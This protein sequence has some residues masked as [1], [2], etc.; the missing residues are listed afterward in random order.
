[1]MDEPDKME[2]VSSPNSFFNLAIEGFRVG[3]PIC[4]DWIFLKWGI[5]RWPDHQMTWF[6]YA[7]FA[8]I[9]PE[10]SQ[11][12]AWIYRMVVSAKV[13]GS[14]ARTVK[15]Q[16]PIIARQR[17]TNL[18]PGLNARLKVL[19][20]SLASAKH[21]L[22]RVWDLG[23]RGN[24]VDMDEATKKA[25]DAIEQCDAS[26]RHIG[27]EFPNN[28]FVSRQYA[29]F[30]L[31]L[32]ANHQLA[33]E[34]SE[35][36]RLLQHGLKVTSDAA[37]DWGVHA[38]PN[39]PD[40]VVPCEQQQVAPDTQ[41]TFSETS[42][43]CDLETSRQDE[44]EGS[45]VIS[46]TIDQLTFPGVRN[47]LL[48][49]VIWFVL[50]FC[51]EIP[52]ILVVAE[53]LEE[54]M[55]A[56]LTFFEKLALLRTQG[57]AFAATGHL[58]AYRT[59]TLIVPLAP[60][61]E[62][63]PASVG[64]SWDL[65]DQLRFW[66]RNLSGSIQDIA[67]Y[68]SFENDDPAVTRAKSLIFDD[69]VLFWYHESHP[70]KS[71]S[72]AVDSA[73]INIV[74]HLMTLVNAKFPMPATFVNSSAV[75]NMVR[76]IPTICPL[77]TE[78]IDELVLFLQEYAADLTSLFGLIIY[79]SIG[80]AAFLALFAL[81]L[82]I[83]WIQNNKKKVYTC[84]TALPKNYVRQ[85]A[86]NLRVRRQDME[87]TTTQSNA[88]S[89]KQED[90]IMKIF[91]AGHSSAFA[92]F[93]DQLAMIVCVIVIVAVY[94]VLLVLM[95][96][97]VGEQA[98]LVADSSPHTTYLQGAWAHAISMV[99][100]VIEMCFLETDLQNAWINRSSIGIRFRKQQDLFIRFYANIAFGN[101]SV[102]LKPFPAYRAGSRTAREGI[103]CSDELVNP[104]SIGTATKC[105]S[106]DMIYAM[107]QTLL[108]SRVT[109]YLRDNPPGPLKVGTIIR[110]FWNLLLFPIYEL[111][112][113][114]LFRNLRDAIRSD[115]NALASRFCPFLVCLLLLALLFQILAIAAVWGVSKHLRK[116]LSLLLHC[117]ASVILQTSRVMNVLS[118]DFA[119]PRRDESAKT[120]TFFRTVVMQLPDAIVTVAVATME[121]GSTN[122]ACERIFGDD[123]VR[124]SFV[125]F[126]TSKF[127]GKTTRLLKIQL[128]GKSKPE[129]LIYQKD[130]QTQVNL[131]ASSIPMG[132]SIVYVFREVTQTVRYNTLIA[133]E[134]S[135]SDQMLRS[136]LPPSLADRVQAGEK[137]ISFAV[138]SATIVFM[139]IVSFTP[140]CGASTADKVMMTLNNLFSRFDVNCNH[141]ST[142]T[143]IKNIGD[144]YMAAG[145]VFSEVNQP[146]E[147]ARQVVS[148]GLDSLESINQLNQKLG[149][150]LQIRV[151]V[152]T[153]GPIVVAVLGGGVGKPTF[154][155]I[156]PAIN[157]A[158]QM[159]QHGPP[160]VVHVSRTVYEL[161]YGDQFVVKERGAVEVKGGIVVTYIVTDRAAN[162]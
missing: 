4:V 114:P 83:Q 161:I 154:E 42:G 105:Y 66:G 81:V 80:I 70:P 18:S 60:T 6:L 155:I 59:M 84:L 95:D 13:R 133:F 109:P 102:G 30:A 3:H 123:V 134:R 34:L 107:L 162:H 135:K 159:E 53:I 147:H 122:A 52:V 39:L 94:I 49:Q 48:W 113:D 103:V 37:H 91:V 15:D 73:L 126:L 74:S 108:E 64:G 12:L 27:R 118:G 144:C 129:S 92:G 97:M 151:G 68:R 33:V 21:K 100:A 43:A 40:R 71:S 14:A 29:R 110:Y 121:I 150:Q 55:M 41:D 58:V 111:L 23:I 125:S 85:I 152:N 119:N 77:I 101:T 35:K 142:M 61:R 139:D 44:F 96:H 88:E 67:E 104:T 115:L 120:A 93:S 7:K 54:R 106:P 76:N 117:P 116:V 128:D 45:S 16:S 57:Y 65:V 137:N 136:I 46:Q 1:M 28:M 130:D 9:F 145:G 143:R 56:P 146:A 86:E 87:E 98:Q 10:Q 140:W 24:I 38:F 5:G 124:G 131:L 156:G 31:D 138:S 47:T 149:E 112:V 26:M 19:A 17:E 22:R 20:K 63:P 62:E 11:I 51:V 75:M 8:A 89:N 2:E 78:S 32:L 25:C 153:G 157:V 132:D 160:M 127:Q 72:L 158:Q 90:N 79:I 99:T 69:K 50:F 141:Y 36:T 148:F 82:E